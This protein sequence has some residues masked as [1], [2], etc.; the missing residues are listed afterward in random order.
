MYKVIFF[1]K[2]KKVKLGGF[3]LIEL[4]VASAVFT[5]AMT[6]AIE[7]LFATQ[8]SY[9][10]V[11]GLR[12]VMDNL[13][14]S[15][16]LMTRDIRYGSVI[17][18]G[19][20]IEDPDRMSRKSCPFRL[21]PSDGGSAIVFRPANAASASVR[22]GYYLLDGKVYEYVV[23]S[24]GATSTL[25]ITGDDVVIDALR[26]FVE[27]ANTTQATMLVDSTANA[28]ATSPDN[29]QPM[30]SIIIAGRTIV[31]TSKVSDSHFQLQTTITTR[32]IDI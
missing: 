25:P 16:D 13:N 22:K 15:F 31:S 1:Q 9:A 4:M 24:L 8:H 7:A 18:C 29:I 11:D 3:T 20:S 30:V 5:I 26:F 21:L 27:G 28:P 14:N 12:S 17:F 19:A 10:K 23:D 32:H 2:L 6:V